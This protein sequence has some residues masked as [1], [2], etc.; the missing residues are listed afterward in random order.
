MGK[1]FGANAISAYALHSLFARLAGPVKDGFMSSTMDAGVA[2]E[3]AS[4]LWALVYTLFIFAIA[5]GM[6]RKRLFL[7]L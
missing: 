2:G 5:Y 7:K 3:F 4:L 6:Y 1:I